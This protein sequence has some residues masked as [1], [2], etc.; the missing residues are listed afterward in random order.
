MG[1]ATR[2]AAPGGSCD[3]ARNNPTRIMNGPTGQLLASRKHGDGL[4]GDSPVTRVNST[5]ETYCLPYQHLTQRRITPE[6]R[7]VAHQSL[8]Y[9]RKLFRGRR[10][11]VVTQETT[12]SHRAISTRSSGRDRT[13]CLGHGQSLARIHFFLFLA[14]FD[15]PPVR[16]RRGSRPGIQL[17]DVRDQ[18]TASANFRCP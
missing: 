15:P 10:D 11:Q 1:H 9:H 13:M 5:L 18:D 3:S 14:R 8:S 17:R 2:C 12:T 4:F 7:K 6:E 16:L